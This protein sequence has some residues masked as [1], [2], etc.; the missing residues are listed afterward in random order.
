M[1]KGQKQKKYLI[2]GERLTV[3]QIAKQPWCPVSAYT[4]YGRLANGMGIVEAVTTKPHQT[5]KTHMYKGK[6]RSLSYLASLPECAVCKATLAS[7]LF[8]G[9]PVELA[10]TNPKLE[11]T[12]YRSKKWTIK[13][14]WYKPL[15]EIY[16]E[17][18]D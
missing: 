9:W 8:H 4:I 1:K 14:G 7:R 17:Y 5:Q 15:E 6:M 18:G 12:E 16:K 11:R 2:G 13:K 10:L 3:R